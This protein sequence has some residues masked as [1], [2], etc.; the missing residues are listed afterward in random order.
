MVS[1]I[2]R[3]ALLLVLATAC[4]TVPPPS[5]APSWPPASE[6]QL[7]ILTVGDT[8]RRQHLG[9]YFHLQRSVARGLVAEDRRHPSDA[10]VLLG[11]NFYSSGLE[12]DEL[13]KRIRQNVAGPYCYFVAPGGPRSQEIG[14]A[15]RLDVEQRHPLPIYAVLGN[16]D[17]K[18]PESPKLQREAV[19]RFVPNWHVPDG[20]AA[21][22]EFEEGV[23]LILF[24]STLLLKDEDDAELVEALRKSR[25]PWRILASHHP[26]AT[27][28][29]YPA[30]RAEGHTG[31]REQVLAAIARAGV[32]V[33]LAVSGHEHNLQ[34][35]DMDGPMVQLVAGSGSKVRELKT[36]NPAVRFARDVAG[37]ARIDLVGG[38]SKQQ[39]VA[40]LFSTRHVPPLP[41]PRPRLVAQFAISREGLSRDI[42]ASPSGS[43]VPIGGQVHGQP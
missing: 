28:R 24:D 33:Q 3:L 17:H 10:L 34:V 30:D 35:I 27:A 8:G 4:A 38:G 36:S 2:H 11:D 23:S 1:P 39:L 7:S 9:P 29:D 14:R 25:G 18:A 22:V 5:E 26:L 20:R 12:S 32:T 43:P 40:S 21:T 6:V 16:H 41:A 15:C 13:V 31:Y 19:P 42:L 37:F